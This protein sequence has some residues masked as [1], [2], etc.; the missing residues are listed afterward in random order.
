MKR[1]FV[2]IT[3]MMMVSLSALFAGALT[4]EDAEE[5]LWVREEEKLARDVYLTLYE[6]WGLTTFRN[7]ADSE[8]KHMDAVNE[9]LIIPYG[10]EDPVTTDTVGVFTNPEL[11]AIYNQLIEKGSVS[12]EDAVVIG[13]MIEDMDIFDLQ[14]AMDKTDNEDIIRVFTSL[15][16]GS[17]NHMRAFYRQ[18]EKYGASY[19]PQYITE[20]EMNEILSGSNGNNGNGDNQNGNQYNGNQG[21]N[22][23]SN[24]SQGSGNWNQGSN[25]QGNGNQNN[26]GPKGGKGKK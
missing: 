25:G 20:E 8:Q 13:M 1:T 21:S 15:E 19:T 22:G 3:I 26:Q 11:Q 24:G 4:A 17:E 14:E 5:V 18:V 23:P 7:I 2:L 6:Q 12:I 16:N 10:L 9:E